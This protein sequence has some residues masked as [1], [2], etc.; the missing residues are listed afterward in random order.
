MMK[1]KTLYNLFV[2]PFFSFLCVFICLLITLNLVPIYAMQ[3]DDLIKPNSS[4]P[5]ISTANKNSAQNLAPTPLSNSEYS[6]YGEQTTIFVKNNGG[7]FVDKTTEILQDGY[8]GQ[9]GENTTIRI[10][11]S[12]YKYKETNFTYLVSQPGGVEWGSWYLYQD[13]SGSTGIAP[14]RGLELPFKDYLDYTF[15]SRCAV[16]AQISFGFTISERSKSKY[17]YVRDLNYY[18]KP[19]FSVLHNGTPVSGAG[20]SGDIS[21]FSSLS[22]AYDATYNSVSYLWFNA[23]GYWCKIANS[24]ESLADTNRNKPV[25]DYMS[26]DGNS[27][28]IANSNQW[29]TEDANA[30]NALSYTNFP[31][32][33]AEKYT[34]YYDIDLSDISSASASYGKYVISLDNG[35]VTSQPFALSLYEIT[36]PLTMQESGVASTIATSSSKLKVC[37]ASDKNISFSAQEATAT[38]GENNMNLVNNGFFST[39][40]VESF[41]SQ[42]AMNNIEVVLNNNNINTSQTLPNVLA[43]SVREFDIVLKNANAISQQLSGQIEIPF[44]ITYGSIFK[45]SNVNIELNSVV[46]QITVSVPM[47]IHIY[48]AKDGSVDIPDKNGYALTNYSLFPINAQLSATIVENSTTGIDQFNNPYFPQ[49]NDTSSFK[50]WLNA[51]QTSVPFV[52]VGDGYSGEFNFLTLGAIPARGGNLSFN[53]STQGAIPFVEN[54]GIYHYKIYFKVSQN[55]ED[56]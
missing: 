10:Q 2:K 33:S 22:R 25:R 56:L 50:I 45:S 13:N 26:S 15:Y 42:T 40:N 6:Y 46:P 19:Q 47:S 14:T 8:V 28:V 18:T 24:Y 35:A 27:S 23:Y 17:R 52:A 34:A 1:R 55:T 44:T 16:P 51:N 49:I 7:S 29:N 41:G 32:T 20:S 12:G 53:I 38:L 3:N 11:L 48:V 39:S 4:M 43:N 37:N 9:V 30:Y 31:V 36:S 5:K 21:E 54:P